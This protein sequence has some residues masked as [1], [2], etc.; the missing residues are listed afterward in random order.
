MEDYI[1][2]ELGMSPGSY[3]FEEQV[4]ET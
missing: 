1:L 2:D 3:D 4:E